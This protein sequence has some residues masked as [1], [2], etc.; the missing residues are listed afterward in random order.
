M[1]IFDT[2]T[3]RTQDVERAQQQGMYED[4]TVQQFMSSPPI[5]VRARAHVG[6][7]ASIMIAK[8]LHRLPVV[9]ASG[10]LVGILSRSDV[11]KRALQERAD[12]IKALTVEA[13]TV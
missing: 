6:E 7:A 5:T 1:H 2:H 9:D 8:R 4:A 13:P 12:Q 3:R 10:H 11:F